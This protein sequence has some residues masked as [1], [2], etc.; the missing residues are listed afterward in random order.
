MKQ[1]TRGILSGA[2]YL[3]ENELN[4]VQILISKNLDYGLYPNKRKSVFEPYVGKLKNENSIDSFYVNSGQREIYEEGS[5]FTFPGIEF[6]KWHNG[7]IYVGEKMGKEISEACEY[8]TMP[9]EGKLILLKKKDGNRNTRTPLLV[10]DEIVIKDTM[11]FFGLNETYKVDEIQLEER[12]KN[13]T[14]ELNK[15]III[16]S[17]TKRNYTLASLL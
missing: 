9:F 15:N 6:K 16:G 8:E 5:I 12:F 13:I 4:S 10:K 11:N 17:G 1:D 7:G 3:I 2:I 14:M